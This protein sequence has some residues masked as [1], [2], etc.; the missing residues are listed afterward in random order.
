MPTARAGLPAALIP[1]ALGVPFIYTVHGFHY[2]GKPFGVRTLARQTERFCILS[3]GG[4]G[5][6]GEL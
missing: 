2:P 5:L 6:R 3:G 4:H 1:S